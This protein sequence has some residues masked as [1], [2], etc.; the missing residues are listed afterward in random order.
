FYN[1]DPGGKLDTLPQIFVKEAQTIRRT[2]IWEGDPFSPK[3][4]AGQLDTMRGL[5][6]LPPI[7][8]YVVAGER[9]GLAPVTLRGMENDPVGAQWQYGLGRAIT[10]TS[11]ATGRWAK[12]WPTWAGFRQFW[13]QQMRWAM[14]PT[15]SPNIRVITEDQGEKTRVV[16]EAVDE[17]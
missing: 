5:A 15:G 9:E 13:E 4:V 17:K 2:L 7:H 10:F 14:R 16:V 1:I 3:I 6:G 11:D 12:T 8:G